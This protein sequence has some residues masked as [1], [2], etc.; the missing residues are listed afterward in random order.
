VTEDGPPL[1]NRWPLFGIRLTCGDVSLQ[2]PQERDL[3]RLVE[4]MPD[5]V[6]QDPDSVLLAG[7]DP[8]AN[9]QRL[10]LRAYWKS[11]A[12]W[13]IESWCL[14]FR[15]EHKGRVV[16]M[17]ALEA[18]HF[19]DLRTVDSWSWLEPDRR[20]R[21]IGTAMRTAILGLAFD[22][23]GA[24]A[25]VSSAREDNLASLGVSHRIG[26]MD[27]G[28]S[29]SR[30]PSGPCTLHHVR[31]TREGWQASGRSSSVSVSGLEGCGPYF[32]LDL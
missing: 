32:G 22:H 19:P 3:E 27:N 15:V 5:D 12:D 29:A 14:N 31:L 25:A 17:Q 8:R 4:I 21:G 6:E 10:L 1:G 20:S 11:W 16:G 24:L 26:Y 2:P 23:L 7:L 30:S 9:R 28:V 13:S 18:E